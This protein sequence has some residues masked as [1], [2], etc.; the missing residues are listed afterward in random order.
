MKHISTQDLRSELESRGYQ[1]DN[2][3]H[4]S[5]VTERYDCNRVDAMNILIDSLT[6]CSIMEGVFL[7]ID[8]IAEE[9]Y[10]LKQKI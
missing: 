2:L 10:N 7:A 5:D 4:I 3:W 9:E 6:N 1:T 8:Q